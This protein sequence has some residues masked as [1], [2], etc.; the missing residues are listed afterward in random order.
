MQM[1]YQKCLNEIE[2]KKVYLDES[3]KETMFNIGMDSYEKKYYGIAEYIFRDL[4][5]R[6]S[7]AAKNNL[8][9]MIRRKET[10]SLTGQEIKE[11]MLLLHEGIDE[12]D[13]FA[14]VNMALIFA[15]NFGGEDD[16]VIADLF[17]SDIQEDVKEVYNW[18][19]ILADSGDA[20]GSLI[21]WWLLRHKKIRKSTLGTKE[22]LESIVKQKIENVPVWI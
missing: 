4:A 16:W 13:A 7:I 10:N 18:W 5:Q 21:H 11:A 15:L 22:E 3:Y 14:L 9:Y 2:E 1:L 17:I 19:K 20:E 12:R 8:A 6:G